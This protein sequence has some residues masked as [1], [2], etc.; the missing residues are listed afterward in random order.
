MRVS[1]GTALSGSKVKEIELE[2]GKAKK[3]TFFGTELYLCVRVGGESLP[4]GRR[5]C[6][7][8]EAKVWW[9]TE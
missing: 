5:A 6:A 7:V 2:I 3:E 9:L 4:S 8:Q 1:C